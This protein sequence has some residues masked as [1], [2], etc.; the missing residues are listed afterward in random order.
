M[1]V[2]SINAHYLTIGRALAARLGHPAVSGLHLPAAVEDETFRDEFGFVFLADGSVGPFYVSMGELLR[3]LWRRCPEPLAYRSDALT[4]LQ[5]LAS[6]DPASRALALGTYNALSAALF[7]AADFEPPERGRGSGLEGLETGGTIGMVGFFGPLVDRLTALGNSVLVLEQAPERVPDRIGVA[8]TADPRRLR[9]C[10]RVLCTASTLINDTLSELLAAVGPQTPIE[11][12]GPSGSGLP[13]PLFARG[14]A[15]VGGISFGGRESLLAQL[16]SGKTW[17][18][19]GRKY[20][21]EPGNYPGLSA[22]LE[23][24][25][26]D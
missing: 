9:G 10:V 20:Q 1:S 7:R 13:D 6:T 23:R 19:A 24:M 17:G 16:G 21:L 22:L 8:A 25:H 2:A 18:K 26:T 14:V 12:V 5:G 11:L 4:L 15:A 3:D